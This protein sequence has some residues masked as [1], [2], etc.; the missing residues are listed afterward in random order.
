[1]ALQTRASRAVARSWADRSGNFAYPGPRRAI[2]SIRR[3]RWDWLGFD[4][5][6]RA[7]PRDRRARLFVATC[8][9]GAIQFA[10]ADVPLHVHHLGEHTRRMVARVDPVIDA[11]DPALLIDEHADPRG[12]LRLGIGAGAV[13]GRDLAVG[14]A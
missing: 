2:I 6:R 14:V 4:E 5:H 11:R 7:R 8:Y 1:M 10:P 13:G 12:P 3:H 9:G